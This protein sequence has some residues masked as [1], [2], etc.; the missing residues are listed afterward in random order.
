MKIQH[1]Y[2]TTLL[3]HLTGSKV[4]PT[5]LTPQKSITGFTTSVVCVYEMKKTYLYSCPDDGWG[6]PSTGLNKQ[7]VF[8]GEG[9]QW[10]PPEVELCESNYKPT[11]LNKT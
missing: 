5:G 11:Y 2:L 1:T 9:G 7:K 4:M 10:D 3:E 6:Y 8:C